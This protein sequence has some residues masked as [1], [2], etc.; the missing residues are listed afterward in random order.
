[1]LRWLTAGESH[2]EA[3]VGILEGV[4]AHV[5][6]TRDDV[7]AALARRRLGYGR[8]ARMKFEADEIRFLGGVRHGR[9]L[10]GPVAIEVGNTEWPKWDR[11]MSPDPVDPAELEGMARAAKLTR[12]RPGHADFV[13][14]Q[15]YDFD[16]SRP[17]LERASARETATRVALGTVAQRL[18]GELGIRLVSHTTAIGPVT[19]ERDAPLP[20]PDDVATLDADP[21]RCFDPQLS[22]RMVAEVDDARRAGDTLGGVVE[23][24]AWG[25]PPGVGSFVHGDRRLDSRLAGA[26]MGI[27]AIKGVEVGDGFLKIGRAHV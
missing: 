9:T 12:P 23:V 4:P 8:G 3:L 15:K 22:E 10:G 26:L 16:E 7:S 18:L 6:L 17:V 19:G 5:P 24:I 14:M 27:Q 25:M 2:G 11:V 13:G 1:M 21:M 20:G